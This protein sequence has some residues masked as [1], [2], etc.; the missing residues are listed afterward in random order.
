MD[1]RIFDL[2]DQ[3]RLN[4]T[5]KIRENIITSLTKD[6][7]PNNKDDMQI[8]LSTLDGMDRTVISKTRL[9]V[10]NKN[11]QLQQQTAGLIA[12]LLSKFSE[13]NSHCK[14]EFV[15]VPVLP[16]EVLVGKFVEGE[17]D[18]GVQSLTYEQFMAEHK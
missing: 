14:T 7:V 3:N 1:A 15:T 16:S 18:I 2:E 4:L 9:N 17:M 12:E 13:N 6:G 11:N 5:L 10:D 8:L